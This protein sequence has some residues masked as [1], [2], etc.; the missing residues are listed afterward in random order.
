VMAAGATGLIYNP[1]K[2]SDLLPK[3]I[4]LEQLI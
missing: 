4:Q 1:I 3:I 2:V